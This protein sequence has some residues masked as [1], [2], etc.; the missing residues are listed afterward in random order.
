ML[1]RMSWE[2]PRLSSAVNSFKAGL[3]GELIAKPKLKKPS[4]KVKTAAISASDVLIA[5][6]ASEVSRRTY[7]DVTERQPSIKQRDYITLS[8]LVA[9]AHVAIFWIYV[10]SDH[11]TSVVKPKK[12]EVQVEFFKPEVPPPPPKV[13]PPP[14]PK[15]PPK[16]QAQPPKP[17][18][19]LR[20]P[21]AEQNITASD[22]TVKENTEAPRTSE[23][24]AAEPAPAAVVAPPPP[25]KEEPI[26]E[27][28]GYAGYMK[29]P[30]PEYPAAALRQGLEGKVVL[31]VRVL[32][33]GTAGNVEVKQSSG[34]RVLDDAAI[35]A[36]KG[37]VFA[38]AKR[39]NTPI[40]GWATVPLE[41]KISQ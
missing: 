19:A 12:T 17:T 25:P 10:H 36:V 40:D 15:V 20:T 9:A 34:K 8:F 29:N 38:P 30:A 14:P 5:L 24:V 21:P 33:N 16:V 11:H 32:A 26:T 37:W 4:A 6:N 31:R 39:G 7:H 1:N 41:F 27:A 23:P 2:A 18:P 13:E 22:M 3:I 28:S 35:A